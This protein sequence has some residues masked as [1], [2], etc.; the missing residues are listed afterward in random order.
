MRRKATN[1]KTPLVTRA[2]VCFRLRTQSYAETS[3]P[4]RPLPPTHYARGS[5]IIWTSTQGFAADAAS[6]W[7]TILS[8]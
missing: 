7:A 5:D 2:F 4:R 3:H 6:P 8:P 1:Q